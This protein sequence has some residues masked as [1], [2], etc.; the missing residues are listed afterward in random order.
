VERQAHPQVVSVEQVAV[1]LGAAFNARDPAALAALYTEDAVLM[2]PGEPIVHGKA[3]IR[4]WFEQALPR[5]GAIRVSLSAERTEGDLAVVTGTFRVQPSAAELE[6]VTPTASSERVGKYIL[7][8]TR[9]GEAW[10]ILWDL[11]NLDQQPG[12]VPPE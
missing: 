11:W 12:M 8:L 3:A 9:A 5:L 2:P 4:A 7:V 10:K 6:V 1:Q